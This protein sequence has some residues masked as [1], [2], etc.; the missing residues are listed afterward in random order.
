VG[1][2]TPGEQEDEGWGEE[3]VRG[4]GISVSLLRYFDFLFPSTTTGR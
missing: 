1:E 4:E 3:G 2:K